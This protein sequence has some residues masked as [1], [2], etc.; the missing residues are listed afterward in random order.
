LLL[1]QKPF[2]NLKQQ[3]LTVIR[4]N[5]ENEVLRL[6]KEPG[7]NISTGGVTL[8]SELLD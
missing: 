2:S 6:K 5:L 3:T 7:K 1:S 4:S 8:P